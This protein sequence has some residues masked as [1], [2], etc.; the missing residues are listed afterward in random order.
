[1]W[2]RYFFMFRRLSNVACFSIKQHFYKHQVETWSKKQSQISKA[3]QRKIN[4][5][6]KRLAE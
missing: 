4:I 1:M 2:Q 5:V 3:F 6:N